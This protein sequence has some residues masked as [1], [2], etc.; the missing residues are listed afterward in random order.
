MRFVVPVVLVLAGLIHLL[1]LTGV[2]G[3]ERLETLYGI[4]V[5]EPNLEILLRHRAVLFGLLG[6]FLVIAAFFRHV[7]LAALIAG[8]VSV[9][10]F[11]LIAWSVGDY[12]A[13]VAR[14]VAVDIVAAVLLATGL[15][16]NLRDRHM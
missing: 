8:A 4:S 2:L 13:S 7:H 1:P 12:N 11:L 15:V 5:Q 3:V 10:S 6:G 16:V 9:V 14:V